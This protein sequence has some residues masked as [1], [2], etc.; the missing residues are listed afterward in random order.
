[1]FVLNGGAISWSNRLQP[2][3][4]IS[5]AEAEYM[6]IASATKEALWLK[7]LFIDFGI[8]V[9]PVQMLCDNQAAIK[10]IKHPIASMRSDKHIDVQHHFVRE[11]CARG[12]VVL[13]YCATGETVADC[14]TKVLPLFK[15]EKCLLGMGVGV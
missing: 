14:M 9:L 12:E 5:T 11:R 2:I 3:V 7:K 15:F 6:Y 8:N 13:Q 1:V 4:A 10:L